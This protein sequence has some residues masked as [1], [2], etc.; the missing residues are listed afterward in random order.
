[1]VFETN[2]HL[3]IEII[4]A[5]HDDAHHF[6]V[7]DELVHDLATDALCYG[8]GA[9]QAAVRAIVTTPNEL[10]A[11]GDDGGVLVYSFE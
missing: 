9:N 8:L 3:E 2:G 6:A 11:A 1:M 5:I 4:P 7:V 10:V